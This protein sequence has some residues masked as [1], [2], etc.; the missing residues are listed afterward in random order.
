MRVLQLISS[1]GSY[2]AEA[3]VCSLARR[4]P[5]FG[6]D[7][8]VGH[9]RY[10]GGRH[11]FRFEDY[12]PDINVLP[13]EH[14][15]RLDGAL[16]ANLR[17]AILHVAPDVIH[18]HGYKPDI[19]GGRLARLLKIPIISTCHLW[20][21]S[22]A[23]L[24]IYAKL[25]AMVLRQFS[26]VVAVSTQIYEELSASGIAD[27][28]LLYIPNGVATQKYSAST[29]SLRYLFPPDA[30]VFGMACRQVHAKGVDVMLHAM[31]LLSGMERKIYALIVGDGPNL[32]AYKRMA[33]GLGI[34]SRVIFAGRQENMPGAFASMD[35]FALP[36]RDEGLPIALLEAMAS[37]L[38]VIATGAGSVPE[39]FSGREIGY[40]IPKE[41]PAALAEAMLKLAL[42]PRLRTIFGSHAHNAVEENYSECR[43]V[44]S[45][46]ELYGRTVLS[47]R[48]A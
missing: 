44:R 17:S 1:T 33:D 15:Y 47:E 45:Y 21:R 20:T 32:Q 3:V 38:P 39:V 28:N 34:T 48:A 27:S 14:R 8:S 9:I 31:A 43:M 13:V 6:M 18:C 41:N 2:G 36:S 22:T 11:T 40:L 24:R 4:L 5:E 16:I 25:D 29:P 19:Y 10:I 12:A 23:A 7:V 26:S 42:E 30:I 35:A 46:A 37:S